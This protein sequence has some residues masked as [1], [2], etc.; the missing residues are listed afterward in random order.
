MRIRY[1]LTCECGKD[2]PVDISLAGQEIA[3]T[4]GRKIIIPTMLKMKKLPLWEEEKEE[5]SAAVKGSA[6]LPGSVK[7]GKLHGGRLGLL[8]VGLII[9]VL[10]GWYL[11]TLIKYP[12]NPIQVFSKRIMYASGEKYVH[13][14]SSPVSPEDYEFYIFHDPYRK[15]DYVIDD[16]LIDIWA[17]FPA[18]TY[19]DMLRN[20]LT[21]SDNF[22]DNFEEIKYQYRIMYAVSIIVMIF[23]VVLCILP[24]LIPEKRTVVGT[25]RGTEWKA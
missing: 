25:M 2:W 21:M 14:N 8:I 18:Y 23:G 3:C 17:P 24:W 11:W 19:F 7:R 16:R 20:G 9:M 15:M 10:G 4:C 6:S 5:K 1:T 13:R 22:Y 12:P